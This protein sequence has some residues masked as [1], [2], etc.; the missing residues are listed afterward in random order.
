ML[1]NELMTKIS[2]DMYVAYEPLFKDK[3]YL[4]WPLADFWR[5]NNRGG[6]KDVLQELPGFYDELMGRRLMLHRRFGCTDREF[7]EI[8]DRFLALLHKR[9]V[10]DP[11]TGQ[12]EN[13]M[14][15]LIQTLIQR[16]KYRLRPLF[17][18][19]TKVLKDFHKQMHLGQ[20]GLHKLETKYGW[21]CD[22]FRDEAFETW[23]ILENLPEM[24]ECANI[25]VNCAIDKL[26]E[27]KVADKISNRTAELEDRGRYE[28]FGP[29]IL[30]VIADVME[31]LCPVYETHYEELAMLV[32]VLTTDNVGALEE[33][34]RTDEMMNNYVQP[35]VYRI[36]KEYECSPEQ[37][38]T[39]VI[40]GLIHLKDYLAEKQ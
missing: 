15:E 10:D 31:H 11:W 36:Q 39:C 7:F 9:L 8:V 30:P 6:V 2:I 5:E 40:N 17:V 37:A 23:R 18:G 26:Y 25:I 33:L 12:E 3:V 28:Y 20:K 35:E 1:D 22:K 16:A 24:E 27:E 21:I 29:E 13:V 14:E 19:R 34:M 38:F 32:H 4:I